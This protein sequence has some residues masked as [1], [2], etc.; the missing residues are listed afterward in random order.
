MDHMKKQ[1]WL[2]IFPMLL[3]AAVFAYRPSV[4]NTPVPVQASADS[5]V[6]RPPTPPS[7]EQ[8]ATNPYMYELGIWQGQVAVFLPGGTEP[9]TVW[10]MPVT[11]LPPY[12]QQSL[13]KRIAV[14]DQQQLASF[15]EDYGS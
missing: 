10:E 8:K 1:R 12:D 14:A 9:V 2:L 4:Q 5:E 6:L 13:E 11:A 3:C 15:M 7:S